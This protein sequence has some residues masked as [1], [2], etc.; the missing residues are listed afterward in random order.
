LEFVEKKIIRLDQAIT[1]RVDMQDLVRLCTIPGVDVITAWTF[2]AELALD[3]SV[4]ANAQHVA[5]WAG[6]C[7]GQS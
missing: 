6:L 7:P 4:F 2:L 1:Q 5:S 3:M